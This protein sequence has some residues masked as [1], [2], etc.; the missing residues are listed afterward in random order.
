MQADD[1]DDVNFLLI[2]ANE[3]GVLLVLRDVYHDVR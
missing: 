2:D 1:D 3:A